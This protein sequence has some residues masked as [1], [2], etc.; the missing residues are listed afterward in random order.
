MRRTVL[1]GV[2]AVLSVIVVVAGYLLLSGHFKSGQTG[3]QVE[4]PACTATAPLIADP[5]K[6]EQVLRALYGPTI[7]VKDPVLPDETYLAAMGSPA[8]EDAK[9]RKDWSDTLQ[10]V[11]DRKLLTMNGKKTWLVVLE[12]GGVEP[13]ENGAAPEPQLCDP[14]GRQAAALVLQQCQPAQPEGAKPV[15]Q[16]TGPVLALGEG[17]MMGNGSGFE[18]LTLGPSRPA[19]VQSSGFVGQGITEDFM[20]M[21][22]WDAGKFKLVLNLPLSF[23]EGGTGRCGPDA[24]AT[25]QP[26]PACRELENKLQ[27]VKHQK[28]D[29]W[30]MA[31]SSRLVSDDGKT[32]KHLYRL[33]YRDG[34]YQ[35][36]SGKWPVALQPME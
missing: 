8:F 31:I 10:T 16:P 4:L 22:A 19:I 3:A 21:Y 13:S 6:S 28:G 9:L 7:R 36:P 23:D 33:V 12:S 18:F 20:S 27:P 1:I 15:W 2:G 25:D 32:H 35:L 11:A 5:T 24:E 30:P 34:K 17:G 29:W 14:C 26:A